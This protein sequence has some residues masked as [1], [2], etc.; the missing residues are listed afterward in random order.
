MLAG[1]GHVLL[2]QRLAVK[3][4]LRIG[5][6]VIDALRGCVR[7][8]RARAR[9]MRKRRMKIQGFQFTSLEVQYFFGI[10]RHFP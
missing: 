5:D 6:R 7:Q 1:G 3:Y 10:I 9:A 4:V 2:K 8:W